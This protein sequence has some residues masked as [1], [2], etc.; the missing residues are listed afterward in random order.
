MRKPCGR[1]GIWILLASLSAF[2][3][4]PPRC[5][6]AQMIS[7]IGAVELYEPADQLPPIGDPTSNQYFGGALAVGNFDGDLY[8]DLAI[9]I[10]GDT[11]GPLLG[12]H[13]EAGTVAILPGSFSGLAMSSA[14]YV[15]QPWTGVDPGVQEAGDHFGCALAVGDFNADG[16]D[17]LAV[18]VCN[19]TVGGASLAGA[20]NVFYGVFN[21]PMGDPALT[22]IEPSPA[23][24]NQFGLSIAAGDINGDGF[25]DLVAADI[26]GA[27]YLYFG[28]GTGLPI[29]GTLYMGIWSGV[30][31]H[32]VALGDFDGDG[33]D[34]FVFGG[35]W[36]A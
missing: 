33:Y 2:P 25:D 7:P 11:A 6:D 18:G 21:G 24:A 35:P 32:S 16:V 20:V 10:P 15:S 29:V 19:E 9:G 14:L 26:Y 1:S 13:L 5:V 31:G 17:D 12:R 23:S 3:A 30:E 36:P 4:L 27:Y 8:Q 22:L 28:S 34:D